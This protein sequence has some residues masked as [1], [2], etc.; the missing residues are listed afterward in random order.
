MANANG[1]E[2]VKLNSKLVEKV[3]KN[4]EKTGVPITTFIEKATEEKLSKQPKT[5]Q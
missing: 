3:R 2:S 5:K 4:K 1:T